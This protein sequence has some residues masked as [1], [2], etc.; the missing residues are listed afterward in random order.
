MVAT[1]EN[2]THFVHCNS[3][4]ALFVKEAALFKEQGGLTEEWGK[5]WVPVI[6]RTIG[7]AR[8]LAA[9]IFG[10]ELSHIHADEV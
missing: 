3:G 1:R 9:V 5:A 8:R 4:K 7:E 6:A 2:A 10:V